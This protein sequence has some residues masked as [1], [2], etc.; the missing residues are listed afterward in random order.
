[1]YPQGSFRIGTTVRPIG[2][3]E[4]D[5]DLVCELALGSGSYDPVAILDAI[6]R[7]LAANDTYRPM[8]KRLKRCMRL[9]YASQFHLDILPGRPEV[10]PNGTLILVPDRKLHMWLP[11]NP[12]GYATWFES[13]AAL[14]LITLARKA[15][16]VPD[17]QSA[18]EKMPLQRVVQLL[19]RWR[20][21]V[22]RDDSD[23]APR[24]IVLT[25]L[26]G[27]AYVGE[28]STSQAFTAVLDGILQM[29]AGRVEPLQV[30]NPANEGELLSEKWQ[31]D[32]ASYRTFVSHLHLLRVRWAEAQAT[33]IP[34]LAAILDELFGEETQRAFRRQSQRITTAREAGALRSTLGSGLLTTTAGR[35]VPVRDNTFFGDVP[36]QKRA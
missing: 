21:L 35:S 36:P 23:R 16:P 25:T 3:D 11:S 32:P 20:D 22:Y 4:F 30:C 2:R 10:P 17:Q 1:M 5:L 24:S 33:S 27:H 19:K 28:V 8:L 13:R 9:V 18:S 7:R 12:K 34:T 29:T 26:A 14:A 6:E 31:D 15:E